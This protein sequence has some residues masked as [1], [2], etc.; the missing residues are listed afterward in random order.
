[1][2]LK[3]LFASFFMI[4]AVAAGCAVEPDLD[5]DAAGDDANA[6]RGRKKLG[7]ADHT[8]SCSVITH[9]PGG[10][11]IEKE[12]CGGKSHGTCW[13][14]ESCAEYGDCCN[15]YEE[16]CAPEPAEC[17]ADTD[18]YLFSNY[19]NT[20]ACEAFPNDLHIGQC[21][22]ENII[23]CFVDPCMA[24]TATCVQG[25]CVPSG[26]TTP[27]PPPKLPSC[28]GNCGGSADEGACYCDSL[29]VNYG[30]CCGD[31]DAICT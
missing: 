29:C 26:T 6:E 4:S 15:D 27:P 14:D 7:K 16:V 9:G 13:C 17:E 25:E 5:G 18:C 31:Y 19:C 28:E 23:M 22:Q 8:G 21:P 3:T 12:F 2:R 30:D 24:Q 20:C 11:L 1:M 10:S